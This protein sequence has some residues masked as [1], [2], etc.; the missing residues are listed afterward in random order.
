MKTKKVV[1]PYSGTKTV[2]KGSGSAI[3][4][5]NFV[6]FLVSNVLLKYSLF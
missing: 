1:P 5:E 3:K 4:W 6:F 2:G